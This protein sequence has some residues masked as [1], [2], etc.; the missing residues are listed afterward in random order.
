MI[1]FEKKQLCVVMQVI[2]DDKTIAKKKDFM[3]RTKLHNMVL[4]DSKWPRSDT[5][6]EMEYWI[7]M[8][9]DPFAVEL[10]TDD[11]AEKV[12]QEIMKDQNMIDE[13]AEQVFDDLQK[14]EEAN[15]ERLVPPRHIKVFQHQWKDD[16]NVYF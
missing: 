2:P 16:E 14:N 12:F 9:V 5:Y 6:E 3:G 7:G 8:G 13:I 10:S 15:A 11:I 1:V 4:A